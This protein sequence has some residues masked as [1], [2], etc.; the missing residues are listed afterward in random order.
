MNKLSFIFA[1]WSTRV[2]C[3]SRGL[4]LVALTVSRFDIPCVTLA[5]PSRC[6]VVIGRNLV[7]FF[8]RR[9]KK[10]F[11]P[12][13][14]CHKQN[15]LPPAS[16]AFFPLSQ[17][18]KLLEVNGECHHKSTGRWRNT[19]LAQVFSCGQ[20]VYQGNKVARVLLY[21]LL[22][23]LLLQLKKTILLLFL[24]N[25]CPFSFDILGLSISRSTWLERQN[26]VGP[27]S[28]F[29]N[30]S[31]FHLF[32]PCSKDATEILFLIKSHIFPIRAHLP[33]SRPQQI[34]R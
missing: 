26:V 20:G 23:F 1:L 29:T 25:I 22:T 9:K 13:E 24:F 16:G 17:E 18:K 34:R 4:M 19:T 10:C 15:P 28:T 7:V 14:A 6:V 8:I 32:S 31:L 27:T 21:R 12:P 30:F 2:P 11:V 5:A 3:H 33:W